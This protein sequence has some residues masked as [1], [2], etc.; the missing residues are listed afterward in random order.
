MNR[1]KCQKQKAYLGATR[2]TESSSWF[3]ECMWYMKLNCGMFVL[4]F[5]CT[6]HTNATAQ[7]A[8]DQ[9]GTQFFALDT[10][11]CLHH[12]YEPLGTMSLLVDK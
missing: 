3:Q 6:E 12:C 7:A 2:I 1:C 11:I 5:T 10:Y 4:A 9:F 8:A